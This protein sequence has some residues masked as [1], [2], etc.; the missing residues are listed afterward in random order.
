[1]FGQRAL[2]RSLIGT[3]KMNKVSLRLASASSVEYNQEFSSA[4]PFRQI[5]GP[6][7][8]RFLK[9]NISDPTL[10]KR[11]NIVWKDFAEEFGDIVKIS[12]PQESVVFIKNPEE[13]QKLMH[14]EGKHPIEPGFD[15]FV[16]YRNVMKKEL[17]TET[18]GLIGHH[19]EKWWEFRSKVQQDMMRPKS[20]MFYIK[21]LEDITLDLI[22]VLSH[23]RDSNGEIDDLLPYAHQWALE[24][25]SA[26]FLDARLGCLDENQAEDSDAKRMISASAVLMGQEAIL[27]MSVPLWKYY[28]FSFYK[29]YDAAATSMYNISKKH[30]QV[31]VEKINQ[32]GIEGDQ[33]GEKSVLS[34]LISRCG[35]DSQIPLVMAMDAL[36]AGIDTTGNTGTMFLYH[37]ATNPDKQELLHQEIVSL[38]GHDGNVTETCLSKMKYL[39]ASLRESM[40]LFSAVGGMNRRTQEDMVLSGYQI[41]AGTWV[42]T[43]FNN[44]NMDSNNFP[45]PEKF[46]PE[47]WLRG[48]PEQ[49]K[50]HPFANIP[51]AHGPR[52]CIGKRFA[53]LE[54]MML[55]V[56][57][58]QRFRLEYHHQPIGWETNFTIKPDINVRLKLIERDRKSVV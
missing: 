3:V 45:D 5:P 4:K 37:L 15:V 38:V 20:A 1:M 52:K 41:P 54:M 33:Q 13:I 46:L 39:R 11:A 9:D 16:T 44:N 34:K 6:S 17:Y 58:L 2:G 51:F 25:I 23:K 36:F 35:K 26:I 29:R 19:G 8:F 55:T 14:K 22:E 21:V 28:P 49:Q 31:A 24:S 56:K 50:A 10:A 42:F 32:E 48:C 40:R 7:F 18:A 27:M 12:M 53:E 57:M 47:R 30:I 43:F